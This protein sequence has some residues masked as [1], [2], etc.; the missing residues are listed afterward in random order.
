MAKL[1]HSSTEYIQRLASLAPGQDLWIATFGLEPRIVGFLT[2][3]GAKSI[4]VINGCQPSIEF[5]LV[6]KA[7]KTIF[8]SI[9][10]YNIPQSHWKAAVLGNICFVGGINLSYSQSN[11]LMLELNDSKLAGQLRTKFNQAVR[12]IK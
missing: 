4:R 8:D 10:V 3:C 12:G 2:T 9:V 7:T 6:G 5:D 11:D 1:Y